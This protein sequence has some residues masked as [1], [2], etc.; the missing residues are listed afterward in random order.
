[1]LSPCLAMYHDAHHAVVD[2][3]LNVIAKMEG[4]WTRQWN[5]DLS[6]MQ[7][8]ASTMSCDEDCYVPNCTLRWLLEYYVAIEHRTA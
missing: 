4:T 6:T 8:L 3:T 2:V 7:E 5:A 1:M